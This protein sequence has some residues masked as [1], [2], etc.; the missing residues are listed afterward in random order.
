MREE[1]VN[2]QSVVV[3]TIRTMHQSMKLKGMKACIVWGWVSRGQ[4]C[5]CDCDC[6]CDC[7][8]ACYL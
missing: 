8:F 7:A 6:D 2:R 1:W 4:R 3:C 5:D